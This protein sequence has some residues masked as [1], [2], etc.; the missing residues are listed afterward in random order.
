VCV[1]VCVREREKDNI[2]TLT[3]SNE[4]CHGDITMFIIYYDV[5]LFIIYAVNPFLHK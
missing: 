1:C 4:V 3:F 2:P 5:S